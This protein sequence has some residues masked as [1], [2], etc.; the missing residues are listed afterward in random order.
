M[1]SCMSE[2]GCNVIAFKA[3][4]KCT[5]TSH[6]M[7]HPRST[8]YKANTGFP[9]QITIRTRRIAR[10]LLVPETNESDPQINGFLGD[11]DNRYAY[12]AKYD[13]DAEIS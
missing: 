4:K 3:I 5:Y 7:Q 13:G 6:R 10:R 11:L 9:S 12:N 8:N 2:D 1:Y